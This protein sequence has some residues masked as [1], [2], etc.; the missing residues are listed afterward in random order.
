MFPKPGQLWKS[1]YAVDLYVFIEKV[2]TD[3]VTY[4]YLDDSGT[5]LTTLA[6]FYAMWNKV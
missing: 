4:S 1:K 5:K 6:S 3:S 2:T